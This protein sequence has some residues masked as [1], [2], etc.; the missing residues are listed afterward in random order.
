MRER[1]RYKEKS[2]EGS[3]K[4]EECR[5]E[6]MTAKN[7]KGLREKKGTVDIWIKIE[8]KRQGTKKKVWKKA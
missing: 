5:E 6:R 7:R 8:R 3:V 2:V 4:R 1:K